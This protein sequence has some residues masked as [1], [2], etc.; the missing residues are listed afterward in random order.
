MNFHIKSHYTY[1]CD[2]TIIC[3]HPADINYDWKIDVN[4]IVL[5]ASSYGATY[6][7][8]HWN[9]D[10]DLAE[11]YGVIDIL[12]VVTVASHYGEGQVSS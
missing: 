7:D 6:L 5:C 11:P 10:C 3:F 12:D 2:A 8:T 1:N 4:D 9:P